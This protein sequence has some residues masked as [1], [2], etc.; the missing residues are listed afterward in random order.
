MKLLVYAHFFAQSIVV[1]E[2]I[3]K[4]KGNLSKTEDELLMHRVDCEAG[5][6]IPKD[7]PYARAG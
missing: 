3:S 5:H 6:F 2:R 4:E 1:A 7:R